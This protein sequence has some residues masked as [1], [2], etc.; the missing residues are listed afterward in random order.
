MRERVESVFAE[1]LL[2]LSPKALEYADILWM[3][4]NMSMPVPLK[5]I[6]FHLSEHQPWEIENNS[7]RNVH[8]FCL[9]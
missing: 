9:K 6:F 7:G 8:F 1:D 2:E 5:F 4:H 3:V